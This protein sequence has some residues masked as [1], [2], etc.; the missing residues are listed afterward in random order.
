MGGYQLM[1]VGRHSARQITRILQQSEGRFR[2]DQR[3]VSASTLPTVNH[4]VPADTASMVRCNPVGFQLY[5]PQSTEY[6]TISS[7]Q[8][9]A[10]QK[11]DH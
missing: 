3:Q 10:I 1:G 5:D 4:C 11:G 6:G 8:S 9:P 2:P 7:L